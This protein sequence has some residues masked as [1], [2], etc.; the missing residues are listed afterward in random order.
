MSVHRSQRTAGSVDVIV[1]GAGQCGLAMS[2]FLSARGIDHVV[3][4]RGE[5]A[6]S[7]RRERW[8]SLRLLTP[9]W[10]SCLPGYAYAGAQP[11]SFMTMPQ[12]V[13][14]ITRYA[15]FVRAP[16]RS[17]VEVQSVEPLFDGYR[18]DTS[19]GRW[20]TRAVVLASGLVLVFNFVSHK[21][22]T[23]NRALWGQAD[24]A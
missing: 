8:D 16:V 1:I 12:V 13:D 6:N 11:D 24:P 9:N 14:F 17:A 10:Q 18:V 22:I 3:F 5:I 2:H 23:F 20:F 15:R 19:Q 7:W 21:W 4:E